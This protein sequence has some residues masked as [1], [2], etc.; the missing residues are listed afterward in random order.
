MASSVPASNGYSETPSPEPADSAPASNIRHARRVLLIL[1]L[2]ALLCLAGAAA[3]LQLFVAQKLPSL[4][5]HELEKAEELWD[6]AGPPGYDMDL[7]IRKPRPETLHI[8]VRNGEISAMQ[9]DGMTPAQHTWRYWSVPG[10]FET[11][12]RE[13]DM[14]EDPV[15]EAGADAEMQWQLRCDFD[16][17]YGYPRQF[18]R[19][20][21]GGGPEVYWRVTRFI[22]K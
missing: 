3:F 18:H 9:R 10:L 11:L 15:H 19:Y 21:S 14:A 1:L 6:R 5:A 7:E 12:E 16:P 13:L 20:V 2:A 22:P 4:S 17:A 8:E